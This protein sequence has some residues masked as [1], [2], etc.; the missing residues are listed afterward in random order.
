MRAAA[1]TH[2][3]SCRQV[4]FSAV[5][6]IRTLR[7]IFCPLKKKL[8]MQT[9]KKHLRSPLSSSAAPLERVPLG[10]SRIHSRANR[11]R[12]YQTAETELRYLVFIHSRTTRT[13]SL[14]I[15]HSP[16][17]FRLVPAGRLR[18]PRSITTF[19]C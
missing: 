3:L 12:L 17:H 8:R 14:V 5:R 9:A 13:E 18:L 10:S 7:S 2:S 4:L 19:S 11:F 6:F 16:K 1:K 15:T